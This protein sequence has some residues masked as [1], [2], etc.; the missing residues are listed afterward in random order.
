MDDLLGEGSIG[1]AF[2]TLRLDL[3][4]AEIVRILSANGIP[5]VLIKGPA[6]VHY[7]YSS[8]PHTR[9]YRDIDLV[10]SPTD[11]TRAQ[12][13]LADNGCRLDR[14]ELHP[15]EAAI[16]M[17]APLTHVRTGAA[18]DLHQGFHGIQ[19]WPAWWDLLTR[20]SV[21]YRIA[22]T[23]VRIP[24]TVG[25]ALI[26]VLHNTVQTRSSHEEDDLERALND[27]DEDVWVEAL[28]RADSL[29]C[30]A[31]FLDGIARHAEGH[32][33]VD[34]L[35]SGGSDSFAAALRRTALGNESLSLRYGLHV[36]HRLQMTK[37][38]GSRAS[39]LF[40]LV[41]PSAD[42]LRYRYPIARRGRAGLFVAG[43]YR[44]LKFALYAPSVAITL[45]RAGH[46]SRSQR[47]NERPVTVNR[48]ASTV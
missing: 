45:V 30:R 35:G 6:T 43:I 29:G 28:E 10:V 5:V 27:L 37:G 25:T 41:F 22:D 48:D 38:A 47:L 12:R 21:D 19:D 3:V 13:C 42:E 26:V 15:R 36:V 9:G 18:I 34:G 20:T 8:D 40:H 4:A 32:R 14:G 46:A 11:F 1:T 7:L 2:T 33:L 16:T 31:S 44:P 17:E 24:D 39:Q 23:T